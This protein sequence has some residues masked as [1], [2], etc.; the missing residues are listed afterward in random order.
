MVKSYL[1]YFIL[2]L[3]TNKKTK[4]KW[5]KCQPFHHNFCFWQA[6]TV[7]ASKSHFFGILQIHWGCKWSEIISVQLQYL[8]HFSHSLGNLGSL[9]LKA[10]SGLVWVSANFKCHRI[11]T[12]LIPRHVKQC[13]PTNLPCPWANFCK[14]IG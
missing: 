7:L 2:K 4:I 1:N 10:A 12:A 11:S 3:N 5:V 8:L 14:R 13:A 6:W 9:C